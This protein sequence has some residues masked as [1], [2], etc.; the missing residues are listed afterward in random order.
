MILI[1]SNIE[2]KKIINKASEISAVTSNPFIAGMSL[3]TG[4]T[5]GKSTEYLSSFPLLETVDKLDYGQSIAIFSRTGSGKT[6]AMLSVISA[7]VKHETIVYLTNRK[8][9]KE[10]VLREAIKKMLGI[11]ASE[12]ILDHIDIGT[13]KVM[14]YQQFCK[15]RG[16]FNNKKFL[17]I[18]DECHCFTEDAT[19]SVYPQ[20]IVNFIKLN[21]NNLKIIYLTATPE[22]VITVLWDIE[23]LSKEELYPLSNN[24]NDFLR[25]MPCKTETRI[26]HVFLMKSDWEYITFVT[27]DPNERDKLADYINKHNA[28]G[29]KALILIGNKDDGELIK[30]KLNNCQ[31]VYADEEKNGEVSVIAANERFETDSLASTKVLGNG[32]SLKDNDLSIIVAET[33]D[34][35]ALKQFIGRVRV[36]I[37]H[38]RGI[39]VLIPD[40]SLSQIGA[41]ESKIYHQLMEF[42]RV[43][44]NMCYYLEYPSQSDPF[45]YYDHITKQVVFNYLGYNQLKHQLEKIK[46]LKAEEQETPHAYVRKVLECYGK[47]TDNIEELRIDYNNVKDCKERNAAAWEKFKSS[48]Q[49]ADALR[50]LKDD[51]TIACNKTGGYSKEIRTNLQIPT[52][53][54]ILGFAGIDEQL[55]PERR[56][57]EIAIIQE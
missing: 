35:I 42:E 53:N 38:P 3:V 4:F 16:T 25:F 7:L 33:L 54:I 50:C 28:D 52:I 39:T 23:K 12:D 37:K 49:D 24:I 11:E 26:Q 9:C 32:V 34:I 6:T 22:D 46:A 10:Q 44:N 13:F 45:V 36:N 41:I 29:E 48:E 15:V 51:L 55:M 57:Y 19:F 21:C 14:T 31:Y 27:Y 30:E 20:K 8:S 43:L 40:Y 5:V 17:M 2:S 47:S 18:C 56:V 1:N